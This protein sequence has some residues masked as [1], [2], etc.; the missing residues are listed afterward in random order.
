MGWTE[1]WVA[2]LFLFQ[3]PAFKSGQKSRGEGWGLGG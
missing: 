2:Y 3:I 1:C